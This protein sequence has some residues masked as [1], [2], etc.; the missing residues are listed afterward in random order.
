MPS[1][2]TQQGVTVS[3]TRVTVD[4]Y[5]KN[6]PRITRDLSNLAAFRYISDFIFREGERTA[7]GAVMYEQLLANDGLFTDRDVKEI[8]ELAEFPI[9]NTGD[10]APTT[11]QVAKWGGAVLFSYE[12]IRRDQRDLLGRDLRRISNTV[13]RKVNRISVAVLNQDPAVRTF[14]AAAPWAGTTSKKVE[15]FANATSMIDDIDMGYT[16]DTVLIHSTNALQLRIDKNVTDRLPR[17]GTNNPLLNRD[18]AG[19]LG[20]DWIVSNDVP[21]GTAL[22]L[23]RKLV[24]SYH[25][26][27]PFYSRVVDLPQREGRLLQ[28]AR[29]T[30]PVVTDPL[31]VVRINGL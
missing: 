20:L 23:S 19:L 9:L 12:K 14:T 16:A 21:V 26:E 18:L 17:E 4:A 7:S 1:P 31:A 15:D 11:A 25:D 6:T 24:G 27:L 2:Y 30:V 3:G 28:A 8:E 5:L 13:V 10:K 29:V 22:V